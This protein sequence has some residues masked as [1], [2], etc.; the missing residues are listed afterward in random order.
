[1]TRVRRH[2]RRPWGARGLI[3]CT[4]IG[5]RGGSRVRELL[6][7]LGVVAVFIRVAGFHRVDLLLPRERLLFCTCAFP[8]GLGLLFFV[9]RLLLGKALY[10]RSLPCP[11]TTFVRPNLAFLGVLF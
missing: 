5:L 10:M 2:P 11:W 6:F 9:L 1:M 8:G 4:D 7:H 3:R